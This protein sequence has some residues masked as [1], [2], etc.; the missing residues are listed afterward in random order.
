M[1]PKSQA[2]SELSLPVGEGSEDWKSPAFRGCRWCRR[3]RSFPNPYHSLSPN[4]PFLAFKS[5]RHCECNTCTCCIR[6]SR[7]DIKTKEQKDKLQK[8]MAEDDTKH[9]AHM[10][11][12]NNYETQH[13]ANMTKKRKRGVYVDPEMEESAPK[14]VKVGSESSLE[15]RQALGV[16]WPKQLFEATTGKKVKESD[17]TTIEEGTKVLRGILRPK[18]EG[19]PEGCT[20]LTNVHRSFAASITTAADSETAIGKDQLDKTWAEARNAQEFATKETDVDGETQLQLTGGLKRPAS[21]DEWD[22][23]FD[24]GPHVLGG[25]APEEPAPVRKGKG[26]GR[27]GGKGGNKGRGRGDRADGD[28]PPP[29]PAANKAD[30]KLTK[31]LQI[32]E[33]VML[34][35]QHLLQNLSTGENLTGVKTKALS[36]IQSK[37]STRLSPTLVALYTQGY[38]PSQNAVETPG[39]KTLESLRVLQRQLQQV[40]GLVAAIND[41]DASGDSIWKAGLEAKSPDF[42]PS[43]QLGEFALQREVDRAAKNQNFERLLELLKCEPAVADDPTAF[44]ASLLAE[45]KRNIFMNR[46][47]MRLLAEL[48]RCDNKCAEVARLVAVVVDSKLLEQ[49]SPLLAELRLLQTLLSASDASVPADAI[50]TALAKLQGDKSLKLHKVVNNFATGLQTINDA[51]KALKSRASDAALQIRL[52]KLVAEVAKPRDNITEVAQINHFRELMSESKQIKAAAT[53]DFLKQNVDELQKISATMK[54]WTTT[55]RASKDNDTSGLFKSCF[56]KMVEAG[57]ASPDADV[58]AQK[59]KEFKDFVDAGCKDPLE[60][61]F[62]IME[63]VMETQE[64]YEKYKSLQESLQQH[65]Q[66][67]RTTVETMIHG[68]GSWLYQDSQPNGMLQVLE[69]VCKPQPVL[70][71]FEG[72]S[73][74]KS[75]AQGRLDYMTEDAL[76]KTLQ[77]LMKNATSKKVLRQIIEM[78]LGRGSEA[79]DLSAT[80]TSEDMVKCIADAMKTCDQILRN[81]KD[82]PSYLG[83]KVEHVADIFQEDGAE[84]SGASGGGTPPLW[85]LC[86]LP[87]ALGIVL[88]AKSLTGW[89]PWEPPESARDGQL[90]ESF[91]VLFHQKTPPDQHPQPWQRQVNSTQQSPLVTEN[92]L[93]VLSLTMIPWCPEGQSAGLRNVKEEPYSADH[94]Q[95]FVSALL[96]SKSGVD[97]FRGFLQ[98]LDVPDEHAGQVVVL[99]QK[100]CEFLE[101]AIKELA[102]E[103]VQHLQKAILTSQEVVKGALNSDDI[104]PAISSM[105]KGCDATMLQK[106]LPIAASDHSKA[107]HKQVKLLEALRDLLPIVQTMAPVILSDLGQDVLSMDKPL[108]DQARTMNCTLAVVQALA[109]PL[110]PQETRAGLA[111][112]ARLMVV[113]KSKEGPINLPSNLDLM[114]NKVAGA[115]DVEISPSK[116]SSIASGGVSST[117][118]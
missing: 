53:Q 31:E 30:V 16:L 12:V 17:M 112:R 56:E 86:C 2:G 104:L 72:F 63:G 58:A 88:N 10:E 35:A 15:F 97:D 22:D 37:I 77:P 42:E 28:T 13:L 20:E 24:F 95:S 90:N 34:D 114:M 92:L 62:I 103:Q 71:Q 36:N 79:M 45:D 101:K 40:E 61:S 107:L 96:S 21:R 48:L 69:L 100:L 116:A 106:V 51:A 55:I 82:M 102:T 91:P 94:W 1:A 57:S 89:R 7:P 18:S 64:D 81:V 110:R 75:Y 105:E 117:R 29:P 99:T 5:E 39:M 38:D 32:S 65:L 33:K 73:A 50:Q 60:D 109:R 47:V 83:R 66:A 46:E 26:R 25:P 9:A 23:M 80:G 43:K 8:E 98:G 4:R 19:C 44:N 118:Q 59:I 87:K 74:W 52:G 113:S 11:I 27:G 108:L 41:D 85:A 3:P 49:D 67:F 70:E 78:A 6:T 76:V 68:D 14:Q 111:R 93:Q 54:A 84:V 115:V